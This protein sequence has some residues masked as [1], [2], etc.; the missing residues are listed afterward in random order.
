MTAC[1]GH[2]L[3]AGAAFA[4]MRANRRP[5]PRQAA[6][7]LPRRAIQVMPMP[8]ILIIDDDADLREM[9]ALLLSRSGD[10]VL[11]AADGVQG[12]QLAAE[13]RPDVIL[14]DVMMPG[15]DGHEVLR[16]LKATPGTADIPVIMLTAVSAMRYVLPLLAGGARDYIVKPF[17]PNALVDRVHRLVAGQAP[18]A[19]AAQEAGGP[20]DTSQGSLFIVAYRQQWQTDLL[21]HRLGARGRLMVTD[22]GLEALALVLSYHPTALLAGLD[23]DGIGG[24]DLV[25]RV[26]ETRGVDETYA[27]G[28]AKAPA[29]AAEK[30]RLTSAGFDDF[31]AV[32]PSKVDVEELLRRAARP[33][34]TFAHVR[35]NVV[36]LAV[37]SLES[38]AA[39]QRLRDAV[40]DFLRAKLGRFVIDLS[41]ASGSRAA[42]KVLLPFYTYLLERGVGIRLVV[43]EPGLRAELAEGA[44]QIEV[45]PSV[46]EAILGW[47]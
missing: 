2:A 36:V 4:S 18:E 1:A 25:R 16:Q 31:L 38:S 46:E 21:V 35:D 17:E 43:P 11:E 37:V 34:V 29:S 9:I 40:V 7:Q 24:E 23:L 14:L 32:P 3:T 6:P 22:N 19:N 15:L 20:A 45:Y 28:L 33:R 26:R 39:L 42:T 30:L 10:A 5:A 8:G 44:P 12:L 47:L 41:Y 13:R 27:V